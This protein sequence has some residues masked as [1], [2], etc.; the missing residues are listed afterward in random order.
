MILEGPISKE[1]AL[2]HD[3]TLCTGTIELTHSELEKPHS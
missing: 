1:W 3:P 2:S